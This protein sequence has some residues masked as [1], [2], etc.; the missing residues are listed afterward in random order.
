MK[1]TKYQD[2]LKN[3]NRSS[4]F[5]KETTPDET[6]NIIKA[7]NGKKSSDIHNIST[8][9]VI[10]TNHAVA[11]SLSIIFNLCIK[12]GHF[13]HEMKKAKIIP[14]HKGDSVLSVAN[15]RPI[16]LLPIF[17]KIFEKLIY[18]QFIEYINKNKILTELQFG[19]QKNK[20]TEQAISSIISHINHA[21]SN[22]L[23]SY[24]IFLDFAKAFD[25]VNHEILLDKLKYY[26]I[27]GTT[28][29]LFA[30][31]LSN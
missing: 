31:Y 23:S 10:L 19:F 20:S 28:L 22:K 27:K 2:Y 4:F 21:K 30:S 11:Q 24:C 6:L 25:T 7:L 29:S 18:N 9:L 13:P 1:N 16:S 17:S 5:L 14:L 3:P 8:D 15:Y 12:E 26:G